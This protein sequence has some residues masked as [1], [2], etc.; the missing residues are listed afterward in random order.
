MKSINMSWI[1][2]QILWTSCDRIPLLKTKNEP[3]QYSDMRNSYNET[4]DIT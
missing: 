3:E 1:V 2:T 4:T